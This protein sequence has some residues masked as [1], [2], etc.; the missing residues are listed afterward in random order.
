MVKGAQSLRSRLNIAFLALVIGVAFF[1]LGKTVSPLGHAERLDESSAA[2]DRQGIDLGRFA[3]N[4][5]GRTKPLVVAA[6]VMIDESAAPSQA[7]MRDGLQGLIHQVLAM[8][9][10]TAEGFSTERLR[11]AILSIAE[12][13]MPWIKDVTLA[14]LN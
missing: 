11:L 10:V 4:I 9:V 8:P 14:E 3:I 7:R 13:N 2:A 12:E 5:P 6:E 1:F